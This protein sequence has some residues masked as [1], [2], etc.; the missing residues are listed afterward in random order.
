MVSLTLT[1][2][3]REIVDRAWGHASVLDGNALAAD[4]QRRI[5]PEVFRLMKEHYLDLVIP[6]KYGGQGVDSVT[7]GLT[8]QRLAYGDASPPMVLTM[9]NVVM[10]M[11]NRPDVPEEVKERYYNLARNSLF[12]AAISEPGSIG[13]VAES[14]IPQ[15][16]I[17]KRLPGGDFELQGPKS[18]VSGSD[19]ASH[20]MV[21]AR[22]EGSER[23]IVC[24]MVEMGSKGMVPGHE[25]DSVPYLKSTNS[26]SIMFD[27][28]RV[29]PEGFIFATDDFLGDVM[30]Q[31]GVRTF[32]S[33]AVYVGVFRRLLDIAEKAVKERTA[34]GQ[35]QSV[36]HLSQVAMGM[37]E[38]GE[39]LRVAEAALLQSFW[40]YDQR[41]DR[42]TVEAAF[43][44]MCDA[45]TAVSGL[46][47]SIPDLNELAG[48]AA[49]REP[50]YR[51]G[52]EDI[53][54]GNFMPPNTRTV[55]LLGGYT[56]LGLNE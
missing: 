10:T 22:L 23:T 40:A 53:M 14:F 7:Y 51:R 18:V 48:Q 32:A 12:C 5:Q 16:L 33:M 9:H 4:S 35:E 43:V 26:N 54:A 36:A 21:F 47:Q 20:V 2:S 8:I 1:E 38:H 6:K 19:L 28:V 3:Q 41:R 52:A 17:A 55:K 49:M 44:R 37:Y 30:V 39:R 29:G 24:L 25:W 34:N 27:S 42:K 56:Q 11:L 46:V 45:K 31:E 13:H 50:A 15:R